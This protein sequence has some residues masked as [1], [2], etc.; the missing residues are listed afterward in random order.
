MIVLDVPYI[1]KL[2]GGPKALLVRLE[3]LYP[4]VML[5]YSTVQMWQHRGQISAAWIPP[6]LDMLRREG[7]ELETLLTEDDPF[8][9]A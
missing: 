6:I 3:T 7:H 1:F 5:N 2:V 9:V 4:E 8:A